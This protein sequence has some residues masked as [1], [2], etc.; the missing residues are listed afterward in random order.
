MDYGLSP[1]GLDEVLEQYDVIR[2]EGHADHVEEPKQSEAPPWEPEGGAQDKPPNWGNIRADKKLKAQQLLEERLREAQGA[3]KLQDK[4]KNP[5]GASLADDENGLDQ[6][7]GTD[8]GVVY[9]PNTRTEYVKGSVSAQDWWDDFT[10]IPFWGDT[11]DSERYQVAD[12]AYDKLIE[13]GLPVDRV[14]GHSLG[15]SV[16]L[17]LQGDRNIDYSRTFGAPVV[18]LNPGNRG[19]VERYRHPLD[20]VPMLDRGA[21]WGPLKAYPHTYTGFANL[22]A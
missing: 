21:T 17:Q 18:D 22:T 2:S 11:K 9:D 19:S 7:Y 16:A 13:N 4:L 5:N 6:A 1:G 8:S 15:G 10:K 20:P 12:K 3:K 14:V